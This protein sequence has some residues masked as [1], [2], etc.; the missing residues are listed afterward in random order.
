MTRKLRIEE[1]EHT[2]TAGPAEAD[3]KRRVTVDGRE[4]EVELRGEPEGALELTVDGRRARLCVA[5]GPEGTWVHHA[6]RVRLVR[7]VVPEPT[8]G[9]RKPKTS[10]PGA[11]RPGAVTPSF[12]SVVVAVLVQVGD[13]VRKGQ[14]LVVVSAMKMESR[15]TAP[16][17]GRVRAV[18]AA[19]GASVK[20]GDELVELEAAG[21]GKADE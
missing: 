4:H 18:R 15:L 9:N 13:E 16:R 10:A 19:V 7:E 8:T 14:E 5:R 6:G 21:E 17:A 20:P 3:G 12:P 1:R 2:V 11:S